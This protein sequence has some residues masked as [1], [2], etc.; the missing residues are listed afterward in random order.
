M[1]GLMQV[2]QAVENVERGFNIINSIPGLAILGSSARLLAAKVQVVAGG[3]LFLTGNV[4]QL[5]QRNLSTWKCIKG[6]GSL[7]LLAVLAFK[8]YGIAKH[9]LLMTTP[10]TALPVTLA[11]VVGVIAFI[12]VIGVMSQRAAPE[13]DHVVN[14]GWNHVIHGALNA[15]RGFGEWC[16]ACTIV[17]SLLPLAVQCFRE[18]GFAPIIG[19]NRPAHGRLFEIPAQA[20]D[21][22]IDI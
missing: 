7:A 10:F 13:W 22:Y 2:N 9:L 6:V 1:N 4:G 15:I 21:E 19:Y 20:L 17:G 5:T 8:V 11:T 12:G 14:T 16:L 18:D 3:I